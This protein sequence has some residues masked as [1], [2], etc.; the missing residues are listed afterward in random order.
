MKLA[1]LSGKGGTGKTTVGISLSELIGK[2]IGDVIMVDC[3]VDAANMHL[4]YSGE[5]VEKKDYTGSKI[6]FVDREL[7]D[8]CG[9]C[10]D[11]CKFDSI[12]DGI[13]NNLTC[14]GCGV[15]RL[16]CPQNAIKIEPVK[17]ADME[18][19][20]T[21]NGIIAKAD[22]VIGAEGSGKLITELKAMA[23]EYTKE[24]S[25]TIIDGSPGVGCPVIASITGA[26]MTLLVI[27]PTKSGL[28]DFLRVKDL[29]NHFNMQMMVC[30]NKY[31]MNTEI[32]IEIEEYCKSENIDLVG[33][34]PF[35]NMVMKS[36]N[37]LIPIVN[38]EDSIAGKKIIDMWEI[39]ENKLNLGV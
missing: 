20:K 30:I 1:I 12:Q 23:N 16:V 38:Y 28:S 29:C 21:E 3:D 18:I 37:E 27:E 2:S 32:G 8:R 17:G 9:I 4:Y 39:I 25:I 10:T 24:K 15:C 26:D 33:K 34:I 5:T 31:D 6:A 22:M 11:Y 36:I 19:I 14:E 7:C 13:V 35:D